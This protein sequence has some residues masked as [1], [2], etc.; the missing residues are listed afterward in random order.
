M[1]I[2]K[3]SIN[4][5]SS[6]QRIA[7]AAWMITY[8]NI[9]SSEQYEYMT[10]MMYSDASLTDQIKSNQI[11]LII[12]DSSQQD[13]G[14]VSFDINYKDTTKTK[15]HKLYVSPLVQGKDIGKHLINAVANEALKINNTHI[16]LNMNRY[17]SSYGFYTK[18]GFEIVGEE[19][20]NIGNGYL[21]EDYIFE[22]KIIKQMF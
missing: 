8:K 1:N 13:A 9:L 14:F 6:I 3:A 22:K 4:D 20:I 2:R 7:S 18:M 21:M 17:N 16:T 12:Q 15:I 11:F 19:D 5:I 10:D